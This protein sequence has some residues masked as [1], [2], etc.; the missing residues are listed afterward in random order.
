LLQ[1]NQYF[2]VMP[3]FVYQQ[4][5]SGKP[6]EGWNRWFSFG[7]RPQVFFSELFSTA[8]E[9]GFDHTHSADGRYD[10]WL[11]KLTLAPQ[12][13]AGRKFF[14]RPV[15]RAFG[16]YAS[17]SNSLRGFVGGVP[18]Q[19]DTHGFTYGLQGEAWW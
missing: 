12:V 7:A 18:F 4:T 15:L 1:P 14:S 10:G 19:N 17:W 6:G 8:F 9:A 5:R 16:T 3:V 2:A 11:Q 13:G